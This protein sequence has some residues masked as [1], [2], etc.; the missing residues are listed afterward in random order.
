MRFMD[1]EVTGEVADRINVHELTQAGLPFRDDGVRT[2]SYC[3]SAIWSEFLDCRLQ[4]RADRWTAFGGGVTIPQARRLIGLAPS[5]TILIDG[6]DTLPPM[7]HWGEMDENRVRRVYEFH[8]LDS[9]GLSIFRG[10]LQSL[11]EEKKEANLDFPKQGTPEY[12]ATL[13]EH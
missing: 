12:E 8:I 13:E 2:N 6:Q 3:Q 5:G 10:W 11:V 9:E 1:Y 4:R 7:D